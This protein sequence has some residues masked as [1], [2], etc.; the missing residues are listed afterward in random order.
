MVTVKM[1]RLQNETSETNGWRPPFILFS[2]YTGG[3]TSRWFLWGVLNKQRL[4]VETKKNKNTYHCHTIWSKHERKLSDHDCSISLSFCNPKIP[5]L[6]IQTDLM[7]DS[8]LQPCCRIQKLKSVQQA[9]TAPC[10]NSDDVTSGMCNV[11][12]DNN[13][14]CKL[15]VRRYSGMS[16]FLASDWHLMNRTINSNTHRGQK[17][18]IS[19]MNSSLPSMSGLT[20]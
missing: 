9:E 1:L 6:L 4:F 19:V 8:C 12:K 11:H 14:E 15:P 13:G 17:P 3:V 16:S 10:A 7:A 20:N 5:V 18:T 2:A